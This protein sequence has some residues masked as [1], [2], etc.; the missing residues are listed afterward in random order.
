MLFQL[1]KGVLTL[2]FSLLCIT[3]L[4]QVPQGISYQAVARQI[5]NG[6]ELTDTPLTV[7]IR[8][9]NESETNEYEET[10]STAS[11]AFG[12]V[13]FIIGQGI[14]SGNGLVAGF[15][16]IN[17]AT[18]SHYVEVGMIYPGV[19]EFQ[20]IGQS[21]LLSVPYAFFSLNSSNTSENDGD[22]TNELITA[23]QFDQTNQTLTITE[24]G[25]ETSIVLN[26]ADADST[27]ELITQFELSLDNQNLLLQEAGASYSVNLEPIIEGVWQKNPGV[28]HNNT[29]NIGI[30]TNSPASTL[31]VNGS[32]SAAVQVVNGTA[33]VNLTSTNQMLI[34]NVDNGPV[35]VNLPTASSSNGRMYTIRKTYNETLN[36]FTSN[37]VTLLASGGGIIDFSA[38]YLLNWVK[39]ESVTVIS[40]GT[41]WYILNYT[42][43]EI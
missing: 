7:R 19:T 6:D 24:G 16:E 42:R 14:P 4:A 20:T 10:H 37:S 15:D 29:E 33:I 12:L 41:Q 39:Q 21:E 18:G 13:N 26:L 3:L 35:T 1:Y 25:I 40:N 36:Q 34:C 17:W 23:A 9:L 32:F 30:G 11:N 22:P 8:I 27:N 2:L 38:S 28:V 43:D 31:H 5:P